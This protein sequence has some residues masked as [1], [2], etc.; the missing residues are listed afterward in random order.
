MRRSL[1]K[2][3]SFAKRMILRA[4]E[5]LS[6]ELDASPLVKI[7]VMESNGTEETKSTTNHPNRYRLAT[8]LGAKITCN[9]IIMHTLTR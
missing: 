8:I 4:L 7:R 9:A 3:R 5:A 2:L 1:S 6:K